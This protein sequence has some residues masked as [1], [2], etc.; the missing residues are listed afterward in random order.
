MSNASLDTNS[1]QTILARLKTDGITNTRVTANPSTGAMDTTT[2]T[3]GAVTPESFSGTDDNGRTGWFAV[4]E[5]NSKQLVAI[6]CD[7]T[8]AVLIKHV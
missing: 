8:G 6:Q 1:K 2:T 4:S 7:S 5:N 3:S